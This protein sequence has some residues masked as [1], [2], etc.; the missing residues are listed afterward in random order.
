M[1]AL[2]H[3]KQWMAV[4]RANGA[5]IYSVHFDSM[6]TTQGL[7][8]GLDMPPPMKARYAAS[9]VAMVSSRQSD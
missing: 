3:F 6:S 1:Q 4:L 2:P 7:N 9:S 5:L 8:P